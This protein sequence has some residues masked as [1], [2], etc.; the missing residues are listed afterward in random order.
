ML[1]VNNVPIRCDVSL[2]GMMHRVLVLVL[3]PRLVCLRRAGAG[4]AGAA[5]AGAR[6]G[7]VAAD[8]ALA[9]L[10]GPARRALA[11]AAGAGAGARRYARSLRTSLT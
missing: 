2:T 5:G 9:P 4:P 11:R 10:A 3:V 8:A 1:G 7:G 6:A